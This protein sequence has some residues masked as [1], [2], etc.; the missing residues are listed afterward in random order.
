MAATI[1]RAG[2]TVMVWN[3]DRDKAEAVARDAGCSVMG[4]ASEAAS[5]ADFVITSLANDAAYVN[6]RH[7]HNGRCARIGH[8]VGQ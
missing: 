7:S 1:S 8:R 3:R 4:S 2:H 6:V 5:A